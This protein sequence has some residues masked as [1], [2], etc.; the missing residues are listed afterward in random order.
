L[1][2][3]QSKYFK[4]HSIITYHFSPK[5]GVCEIG[6][7]TEGKEEDKLKVENANVMGMMQRWY[8]SGSR[9]VSPTTIVS[10]ADSLSAVLT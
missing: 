1:A 3:F 10:L 5:D 2:F 9:G 8:L 6:I 4:A 7:E